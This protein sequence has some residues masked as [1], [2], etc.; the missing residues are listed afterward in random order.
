MRREKMKHFTKRIEGIWRQ[1][2]TP[3]PPTQKV[4]VGI[5]GTRRASRKVLIERKFKRIEGVQKVSV[6]H[7]KGN[8]VVYYET[9]P[10][11][12]KLKQA[13][14]SGGYTVYILKSLEQFF[15]GGSR[16]CSPF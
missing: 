10:K 12:K 3:G 14:K 5:E 11:F 2:M 15:S 6:N 9:K 8:V 1:M 7:A 4:E 13:I 16:R